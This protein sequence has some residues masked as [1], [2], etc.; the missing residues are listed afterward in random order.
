MLRNRTDESLATEFRALRNLQRPLFN[1]LTR[2]GY[3]I[4]EVHG[5][6]SVPVTGFENIVISQKKTVKL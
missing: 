1:E 4:S 2:R 3:T 5:H 6:S